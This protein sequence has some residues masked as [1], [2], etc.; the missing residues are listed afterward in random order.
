MH[1]CRHLVSLTMYA[2]YATFAH[3]VALTYTE[4]LSSRQRKAQLKPTGAGE[5]AQWFSVLEQ[6]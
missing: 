6:S 4:I 5:M 2:S 1:T 3:K